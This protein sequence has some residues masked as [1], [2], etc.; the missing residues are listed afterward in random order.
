[1]FHATPRNTIDTTILIQNFRLNMTW[2]K[3]GECSESSKAFFTALSNNETLEHLNLSNNGLMSSLG[4]SLAFCALRSNISLKFIDLS[5]NK[6]GDPAGSALIEIL[7]INKNIQSIKLEGNDLSIS[8]KT[9]IEAQLSHNVQLNLKNAE[10]R[11]KTLA[12]NNELDFTKDKLGQQIKDLHREYQDLEFKGIKE[13]ENLLFELGRLGEQLK[14]KN[15]EFGALLEKLTLTSKALQVAEEKIEHL[16]NVD[17]QR[18]QH[19]REL[20]EQC[21]E[22]EKIQREVIF[23]RFSMIFQKVPFFR[24]KC[25][26]KQ[27]KRGKYLKV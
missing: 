27:F 6:L 1:M 9:A 7:K 15:Q 18:N 12:L 16:E 17:K 10:M 20:Q 2:C 14:E 19:F 5:W 13:Q 26:E 22:H 23:Y 8:I 4:K 21:A 24:V 25:L 11:S 3:I